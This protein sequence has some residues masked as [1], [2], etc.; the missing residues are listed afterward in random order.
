LPLLKSLAVHLQLTH[1]FAAPEVRA[2]HARAHDLCKDN[3]DPRATFPVLWGIWLAHKVRSE[4]REASSLADQLLSIAEQA[5]DPALLL[6]AYQAISVTSL[7]I[8]NPRRTVEQIHRAAAIYDPQRHAA[9]TQLFGQDPCVATTAFGAVA[10]WL[11]NHEHDALAASRRAIDLATRIAQPSSIALAHHFAAMLH[12]LRGDTDAVLEHSATVIQLSQTEGFS[13]WLAG[14]TILQGWATQ[15]IPQIRSGIQAWLATGSRTYHTYHLGLL[16]D[17]LLQDNR[18]DQ[19][20]P[21]LEEALQAAHQLPEGI[22]EPRLH[23]LKARCLLLH[24]GH[25]TRQRAR[26][27]LSRATTIARAQGAIAFDNTPTPSPRK[28]S[29]AT[30]TCACPR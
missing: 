25:Q 29:T 27:S 15:D 7:C 13:F 5:A 21:I 24:P 9:N 4:L 20:L 6:Q 3:P 14:G 8:G 1:G 18:P 11:T 17:A 10:L 23:Y 30:P 19:A 26:E 16:A 12:Q 28:S 22:H 2:V